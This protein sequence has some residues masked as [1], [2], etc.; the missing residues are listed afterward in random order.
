M[1]LAADGFDVFIARA[2][3]QE[4]ML[5]ES[6]AHQRVD[7]GHGLGLNHWIEAAANLVALQVDAEHPGGVVGAVCGDEQGGRR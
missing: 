5:A 7:F 2:E 3:H 4:S 1:R 6:D